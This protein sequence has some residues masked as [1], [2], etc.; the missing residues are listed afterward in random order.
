MCGARDVFNFYGDLAALVAHRV[1]LIYSHAIVLSDCEGRLVGMREAGLSVSEFAR[2]VPCERRIVRRWF[3][4]YRE[5]GNVARQAGS[6][7]PRLGMK[8][9][10]RRLMAAVTANRL[11][12]LPRLAQ[13]CF[14]PFSTRTAYRRCLQHGFRSYRSLLRI[15][16]SILH[17][18]RRLQCSTQ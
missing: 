10:Y 16:L 18:Q 8:R 13:T 17:R 4:Q 6:S 9:D 3:S 7:R 15:P 14:S 11:S 12:S 2:R 1:I 5:S